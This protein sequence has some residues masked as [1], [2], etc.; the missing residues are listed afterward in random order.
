[1]NQI[2]FKYAAMCICVSFCVCVRVCVW[3]SFDLLMR[4]IIVSAQCT[5]YWILVVATVW[6]SSNTSVIK[7]G[8]MGSISDIFSFIS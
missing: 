2:T 3:N 6:A 7:H 8:E 1:M 5:I 4:D